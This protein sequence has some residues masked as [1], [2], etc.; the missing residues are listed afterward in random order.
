MHLIDDNLGSIISFPDKPSESVEIVCTGHSCCKRAPLHR[1]AYRHPVVVIDSDSRSVDVLKVRVLKSHVSCTKFMLM[2]SPKITSTKPEE[3]FANNYMRILGPDAQF[4]HSKPRD[5]FLEQGA[6]DHDSYIDLQHSYNVPIASMKVFRKSGPK[7]DDKSLK[8]LQH[9]LRYLERPENQISDSKEPPRTTMNDDGTVM[10]SLASRNCSVVSDSI[11]GAS[12][13]ANEERWK[14]KPD[15]WGRMPKKLKHWTKVEFEVV[16]EN[17]K[18]R[19]GRS[20]TQP[21]DHD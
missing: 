7:L 10:T 13:L 2:S 4:E 15:S 12:L 20:G 8:L 14:L 18:D 19:F 3:R 1:D 11:D 9:A 21:Q 17:M 5:L 16:E 6:M